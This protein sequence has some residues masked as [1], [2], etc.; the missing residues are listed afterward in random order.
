MFKDEG[1][2]SGM[3]RF[4]IILVSGLVFLVVAAGGGGWLWL[5]STLPDTNATI[6]VPALG[7]PVEVMR[8][9]TGIPHIF[10]KSSGDAYFALGFVHAQDRFWQMETM[11]R[12]GAGRLS[13]VIGARG[14]QSDKWM[15]T[16]GLYRLAEQKVAQLPPKTLEALNLYAAGVNARLKHSQSLPWGVPAP[17][18]G[19]LRYSPEPWK[20][21]DSLV[22]GKLMSVHLGRNW[23]DEI[24]RARLARKLSPKQVGEMWPLY[25]EDA[26]LTI[27]KTVALLEGMDLEKLAALDPEP[28]GGPHGASNAWVIAN[29]K[30]FSRGSI[31]ANDPH[32][33]FS[34]PILWYLARIDAPDLK[35]TGATVPGVPFTI[36]GH[37]GKIAWGMTS[38][39]SDITDLFVEQIDDTGKKYKT[40]DGWQ[41]FETRTE[42]IAVKGAQPVT[43]TVRESRHGPVISDLLDGARD[44]AGKGAAMALSAVY[45]EPVDLTADAFFRLNRAENWESFKAALKD[46]QGP[47]SNF[48]YAD[49]KGDIGFIAPGLAPVRGG[50]WGLVPSPGW[51]GKTDWT[52]YVPFDELPEVFNP[53]SGRI[54]N[55]NNRITAQDYP[56]FL[57]FDWSPGYRAKRILEVVD[58]KEQ[59]VHGATRLQQ[60]HISAMA[61]HLLPMILDIEPVDDLG[62]R[63]LAMLGK[64][65]GRMSRGRPEPLIFSTWLYELNRAVYADELGPL[66]QDY[67]TLRPRFIVSVLNKRQSWCNNVNTPEPEDCHGR[68]S[69]AFKSA[70]DRLKETH[71]DDPNAWRWGEVHKALF[72][73]PLLSKIPVLK[74]FGDLEIPA[75]GGN[76]TVNRGAS[77]VNNPERPFKDIHGPG[78]RAV[79]DLEDLRRS[80][81]VIATGQSGNPVSGNYSDLLTEWRDGRYRRMGHSRAVMR[82]GADILT[83]TPMAR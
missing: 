76:Y 1:T 12:L 21:A 32:L 23:R 78:F 66:F 34:A 25:P 75:D 38:T 26:P 72:A 65:K 27:E 63:A 44:A 10:A 60:D 64:W 48:L 56:H 28:A 42:T 5:L 70:L 15:R 14:V 2:L 20:P 3:K 82:T 59:T 52:G 9:E 83:L 62:R 36:L 80:R 58:T 4:L 61:L 37:N 17:E 18:F 45:L 13:E 73:H 51:D 71:G 35:V 40:Q 47:Q 53:P 67:L 81:F 31:L 39:Q 22:W 24:L 6:E 74:R 43:I 50:G 29:R 7:S 57:S 30:T 33:R 79:Y 16:L 8:D 54:V 69:F 19:P 11:R 55:A 77:F 49:T 41:E 68:I 46:F